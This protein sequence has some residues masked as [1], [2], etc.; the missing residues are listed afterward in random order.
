MEIS[1]T[2]LLY[3]EIRTFQQKNGHKQYKHMRENERDVFG[4]T[5]PC[6]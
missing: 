5:D 4:A 2:N 3:Y 1:N 6:D